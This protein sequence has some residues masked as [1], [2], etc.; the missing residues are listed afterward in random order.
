VSDCPGTDHIHH[1][2]TRSLIDQLYR[3]DIIGCATTHPCRV[4][5]V[6]RSV[7]A[8]VPLASPTPHG[9]STGEEP[10]EELAGHLLHGNVIDS[11]E[12]VMMMMMMKASS[13]N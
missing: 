13:I 1:Y 3:I 6:V 9:P 7:S 11:S 12:V 2:R 5:Y 4:I 10:F 8:A